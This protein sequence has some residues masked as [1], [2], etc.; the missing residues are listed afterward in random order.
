MG[1]ALRSGAMF[2]ARSCGGWL[3]WR[4]MA[5]RGL[6]LIALANALDGMSRDRA[7]KQAG[8]DRQTLRDWV[9][10]FNAEGVEGLG[11]RPRTGRPPFLSEGQMAA[12]KALVLRGPDPE[13]DGLGAAA[14]AKDLCR[15]VEKRS[16]G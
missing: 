10:R 5:V 7:A 2:R 15:L 4:R 3:G 1:A 12:F 6:P 16:L 8:M 14:T 11:D 9:I 13:R